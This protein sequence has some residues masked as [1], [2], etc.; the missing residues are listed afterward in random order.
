MTRI[1]VIR[2]RTTPQALAENRAAISRIYAE[3]DALRPDGFRYGTLVLPDEQTFIH[4]SVS[5][6]PVPLPDLPA[7]QEFQRELP[8]RIVDGVSAQPA[9]FVG[10]YRIIEAQTDVR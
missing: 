5:D 3:L 1:Q 7:F 4:L 10:T 9:E 6:G 2:Y 8:A